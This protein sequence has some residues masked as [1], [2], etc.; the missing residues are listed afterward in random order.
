MTNKETA[1]YL[2]ERA[3]DEDTSPHA[4]FSWPTDL[5]GYD[6]HIKFVKHRNEHWDE[7]CEWSDFIREYAHSLL[8]EAEDAD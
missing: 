8:K 7:Q 5:C 1:Q 6:Q 4:M 2:H 3:D